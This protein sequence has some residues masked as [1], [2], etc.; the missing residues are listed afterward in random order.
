MLWSHAGPLLPEAWRHVLYAD[1]FRPGFWGVTIFFSIS[2]FLII[3]QLLDVVMARRQETLRVFVL[4]L[5]FRTVPT[6][7]ILLA[8]LCSTG[9]VLWLGW[10]TFVLNAFFIQGQLIG[11]SALLPVSWSLVIEEW[12]YLFY[13]AFAGLLL[14][15][16][17]RYQLKNEALELC[18]LLL[19][20]ILPCLSGILRWIAL[21]QGASVK[22]LKQGLFMQI[23]AL[24]YGGLLAWW[25]RRSPEKFHRVARSGVVIVPLLI[26]V[27]SGVSTSASDLFRDVMDPLPEASRLWI[28][29]GF[30]PVVGVLAS[31]LIAASWRFRYSLLPE[32]IYRACRELS[33]CSYSVYLLHMPIVSLLLRFTMPTA[34]RLIIYLFGSIVVGSLSWRCLERP[35][36]RLRTRV[37]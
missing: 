5:L 3:G 8:L 15:C 4:R 30:Y 32:A 36:M 26:V 27:I 33:R 2:G 35:F 1:W 21:D 28:A 25:L 19:L 20:L 17:R 37:C 9:V 11:V 18:F 13:A 12:S 24:A 16:R 14:L 34:L 22:T 31:A 7:W 29:F 10:H 6:Y 23:D